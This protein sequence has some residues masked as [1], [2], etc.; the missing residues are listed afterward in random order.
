MSVTPLNSTNRVPSANM[1]FCESEVP[2]LSICGRYSRGVLILLAMPPPKL[3]GTPPYF[4]FQ[5]CSSPG[6]NPL[7][8]TNT[9][10]RGVP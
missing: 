8:G 10:G 1:T 4:R 6:N 5:K 2:T 7:P 9:F 3:Y